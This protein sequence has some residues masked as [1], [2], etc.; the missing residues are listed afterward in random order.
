LSLLPKIPISDSRRNFPLAGLAFLIVALI[1]Q[2]NALR[3]NPPGFFLDE[4]SIAYNAYTVSQTGKDEHGETWP[5]FFKAFGEYKNPVYIYLLATIFRVTGPGIVTARVLSGILGLAT[6]ILLGVL[7]ARISQNRTVGIVLSALCLLTPWL[8][9]ISRLVLEVAMYPLVLVLFLS[10]LW[11]A[12]GKEKWGVTDILAL[13]L[14]LALL[15]YTYSIGRLFAPL[16]AFGLIIFVTRKRLLGIV[17]TWAA[18]LVTL[19]PLMIFN[20]HHPSA[21]TERFKFLSYVKPESSV[22]QVAREFT[23]HYVRNLNPW[24]LFFSESS[25]VNELLHVPGPPAML[26]VTML[27][28]VISVVVL[29]HRRQVNRWL[30]F[31]LYG[32]LISVVPA[33]LTTDDFHMLRLAPLPLFLLLLTIPAVSKFAENKSAFGRFAVVSILTLTAWQGLFFHYVYQQNGT[34]LQRRHTFDADYPGLIF[35]TALRWAG[36]QPIHLADNSA[37]PAYVQAYWYATLQGI[38][39]NKFV[40]LGFEDSPPE[41]AVVISTETYCPRCQV[42]AESEP[43]TT[44][45]AV[46]PKP[47]LR[48]LQSTEMSA[49]LTVESPPP[50]LRPGQQVK[51]EVIVKNVSNTAWLSG[52]RSGSRYRISLGN[53]WLDT[54]GNTITNDDGRSPVL[55][56]L[57]PN[58][59]VHVSLTVNAPRRVGEYLLELDLLQ[60]GVSWFGLKG[61][62]TWRGRVKVE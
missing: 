43:Y 11:N 51:I 25:K 13:A 9:E 41:G 3:T 35:P 54:S 14:S 12:A 24:R 15:T 49:E 30:V 44:Y 16:L 29:I 33:S 8:F 48:P 53:H 18:F 52:D 37:R 38:P 46:G 21:L 31:V 47:I 32:L 6:V 19:I 5:L 55:M 59:A 23:T 50:S 28:I 4:S 57:P 17:L 27:L 34:T 26:G 10:T 2:F 42:L 56:D 60:E 20:Y 39:L 58:Q 40:N 61:S 22:T 62:H 45:R 7:A 36:N 1:I